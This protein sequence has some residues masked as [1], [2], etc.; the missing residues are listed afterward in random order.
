LWAV[1]SKTAGHLRKNPT[2]AE[3]KL[4]SHLHRKQLD[5]YRF[6]RQ[7]PIG[8]YIV[9]FVCLEAS[10]IIEVDHGQHAQQ[11]AK[12]EARTRVLE[13]EGLGLSVSGTTTS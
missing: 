9:G 10:L 2:E 13:R 5:G 4:W 6:R 3:Q 8:P 7:R 12:D 11:L 1:V